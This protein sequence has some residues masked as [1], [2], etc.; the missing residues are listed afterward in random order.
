LKRYILIVRN[1]G[2]KPADRSTLLNR[3]RASGKAVVDVRVGTNHVEF[4]LLSD[5]PPVMEGFELLEL[6]DLDNKPKDPSKALDEAV[7]LFDAERFWESH[8]AL[9]PL[10]Q[11]SSN[12]DR[13]LYHGLL[14]AAAAFVHLQK[15]DEK[16]FESIM[17]RA[18]G[19]FD[20]DLKRWNGFSVNK[21][22]KNLKESLRRRKP[23]KLSSCMS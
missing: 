16:G 19:E 6:V 15:D 11:R 7:K 4:D 2:Y 1:N 22:V 10:W 14:L 5:N 9:E 8:E 13:R 20:V 18:L 23:F 12:I 21:I 3:A 17:R